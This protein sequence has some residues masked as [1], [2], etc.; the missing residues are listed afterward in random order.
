MTITAVYSK[1]DA[2]QLSAIVGFDRASRMISSE[3]HV[4]MFMSG[5]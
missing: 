2:L 4:H 5:Q 1:F 3:K